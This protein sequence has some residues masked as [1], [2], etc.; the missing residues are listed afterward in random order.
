M[1][2]RPEHPENQAPICMSVAR[3]RTLFHDKRA[4]R[5]TIPRLPGRR[6]GR[7]PDG[8]GGGKRHPHAALV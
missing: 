4:L 1:F 3:Q 2:L 8:H 6:G 7:Q 5:Q